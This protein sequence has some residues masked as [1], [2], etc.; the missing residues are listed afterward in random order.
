MCTSRVYNQAES[1]IWI[2]VRLSV[3]RLNDSRHGAII[4]L[5]S[6]CFVAVL[7]QRRRISFR[8]RVA[9]VVAWRRIS[10]RE[11]LQLTRAR[12][13]A[14][15]RAM[16]PDATFPNFTAVSREARRVTVCDR[17]A[18]LAD[19]KFRRPAGRICALCL[20]ES[21]VNGVHGDGI[22]PTGGSKGFQAA[23]S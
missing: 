12:S 2:D 4:H 23:R 17:V 13:P 22:A 18:P 16:L 14:L 11:L 6:V 10:H 5:P 20:P 19:T 1:P 15:S 3:L 9:I 7:G 8:A 21:H